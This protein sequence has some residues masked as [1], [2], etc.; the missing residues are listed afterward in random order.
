MGEGFQQEQIY[1][2]VGQHRH[3]FTENI[4]QFV[5]HQIDIQLIGFQAG[6]HRS[7][8][9]HIV[10]GGLARQLD[11]RAVDGFELVGQTMC[12]K[13]QPV[14]AVGIGFDDIRASVHIR[15]VNAGNQL[16]IG[17]AQM[18][19]AGVDEHPFRIDHRTHGPIED[20]WAFFDKLKY[21]AHASYPR[22]G[23]S[24]FS[25]SSMVQPFRRA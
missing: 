5:R 2:F 9:Q 6:A 4:R 24:H 19:V 18:L 1:S 25:T 8:D 20:E 7:G 23:E 15:L 11:G 12:L 22:L 16:G 17:D 13:L 10:S 14:R 21:V 3:V